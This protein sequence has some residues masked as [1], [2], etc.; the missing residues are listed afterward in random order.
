MSLLWGKVHQCTL[1]T[2]LKRDWARHIEKANVEGHERNV[3]NNCM[4]RDKLG[5]N[6]N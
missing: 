4:G 2:G 1:S 5:Q 3:G 6:A